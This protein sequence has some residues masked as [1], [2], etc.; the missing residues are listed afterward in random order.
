MSLQGILII[1]LL[2][3]LVWCV[4]SA[5]DGI[6]TN[7][8]DVAATTVNTEKFPVYR[9]TTDDGGW[10]SVVG[11]E[12][13]KQL[14]TTNVIHPLSDPDRF[15]GLAAAPRGVLLYGPPGTGKT[16]VAKAVAHETSAAFLHVTQA[17]LLSKWIGES[18]K[19][20]ENLFDTAKANEPAIVFIDEADTIFPAV[21]M[22]GR[23]GDIYRI[24]NS[25]KVCIDGFGRDDTNTVVVFGA[26]NHPMLIDEAIRSRFTLQIPFEA[27]D[28]QQI[29]PHLIRTEAHRNEIRI[30]SKAT[31]AELVQVL[32][33]DNPWSID[34]R[35]AETLVANRLRALILKGSRT[36][37]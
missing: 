7:I 10:S 24:T 33:V 17:Q 9:A 20:I 4:M 5:I 12:D 31:D 13:I 14:I 34:A 26:T 27:A 35:Y 6:M 28:I 8:D 29:L 23:N 22:T 3:I 19:L 37:C 2:L 21:G 18:E 36:W 11:L 15:K 25:F 16:L 1:I 30:P 32:E